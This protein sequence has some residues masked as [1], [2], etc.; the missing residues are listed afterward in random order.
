M[1]LQVHVNELGEL[2]AEPDGEGLGEVGHGS[3]EAVVVV[4]QVVIQSLG[5]GVALTA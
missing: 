3:D 5:V 2:E 1:V 4:Q